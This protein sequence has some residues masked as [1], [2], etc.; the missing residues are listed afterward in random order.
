[1]PWARFAVIA[2]GGLGVVTAG[3]LAADVLS[4]HM[5]L[6]VDF[7]RTTNPLYRAWRHA[8]PDG[9]AAG[10]GTAVARLVWLAVAGGLAVLGWRS[11]SA[12]HAATAP[13]ATPF[14]LTPEPKEY[15][16]ASS[17]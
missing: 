14:T 5:T 17:R 16:C 1:V 9:R 4:G 8:L 13:T 7:E 6:I 2:L 12:P 15:A 3:W 11:A 10:T